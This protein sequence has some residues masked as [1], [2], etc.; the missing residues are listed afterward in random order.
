MIDRT[1]SLAGAVTLG[2]AHDLVD[3]GPEGA[4]DSLFFLGQ[5]GQGL[6]IP[7]RGQVGIEFPLSKQQW[8]PSSCGFQFAIGWSLSVGADLIAD[9]RH[10]ELPDEHRREVVGNPR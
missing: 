6:G 4:P 8:S 5:L 2:H 7:N 10:E 3:L 1:A 9:A